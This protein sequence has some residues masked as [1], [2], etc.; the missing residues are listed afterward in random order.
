M[1]QREGD[2]QYDEPANQSRL[3]VAHGQLRLVQVRTPATDS[4]RVRLLPLKQRLRSAAP[5][6]DILGLAIAP[7][8]HGSR[9]S[10]SHQPLSP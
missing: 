1:R 4:F 7:Q 3:A 9:G 10:R 8:S 2:I 5:S 6:H